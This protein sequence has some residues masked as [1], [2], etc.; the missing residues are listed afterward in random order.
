M[1]LVDY[2]LQEPQLRFRALVVPDKGRLQH[3][4]FGQDHSTWYYKMFY[5]LVSV[6][7]DANKEASYRVYLDIKD[8]KSARATETLHN[9]LKNSIHDF[10]GR[11]ICRVQNVR[12]H[13]V[14]HVQLADLLIGAVAYANRDIQASEAKLALVQKISAWRGSTLI[15]S[16]PRKEKKFN[17]FV[18]EPTIAPAS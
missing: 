11:V 3:D 5:Y 1:D 14:A 16:T 10:Q 13:E 17:L 15:R 12:S 18:W 7:V 9:V 8:S 4:V 2:F 6:I